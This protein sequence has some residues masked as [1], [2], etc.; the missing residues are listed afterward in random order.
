MLQ[1][2]GQLNERIK[3]KKADKENNNKT[4]V[5]DFS[6]GVAMLLVIASISSMV[7]I[8]WLGTDGLISRLLTVPSMIFATVQLIVRFTK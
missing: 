2:N 3:M 8:I 5:K 7:A 1:L 4:G 6:Q